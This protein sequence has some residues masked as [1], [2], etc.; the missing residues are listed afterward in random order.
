MD[1]KEVKFTDTPKPFRRAVREHVGMRLDEI[2][3]VW[4]YWT[5]HCVKYISF[6]NAGGIIAVL[7]FMNSR[8]ITFVSLAGLALSLFG[9]G[10]ILVG[11]TIAYMF[12]RIKNNYDDMKMCADKFFTGNINWGEFIEKTDKATKF[13]KPAL[14]LGWLSAISFFAGLIIGIISFIT[15][16]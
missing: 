14:I 2:V 5:E 11:I 16:D 9:T 8:N 13:N 15:Y 6:T 12:H 3:R 4:N 1:I 10:L 7:T